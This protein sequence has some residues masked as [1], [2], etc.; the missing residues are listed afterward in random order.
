MYR[1]FLG[2]IH[3][4]LYMPRNVPSGGKARVILKWVGKALRC[5]WRA[6]MERVVRE[7]ISCIV[8]VPVVGILVCMQMRARHVLIH[9]LVFR[10]V[11]L[12]PRL[13]GGIARLRALFFDT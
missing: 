12:V 4:Y 8:G 5:V 7:A 11:S 3:A 10:E 6:R 1:L 9:A 2:L 13:R